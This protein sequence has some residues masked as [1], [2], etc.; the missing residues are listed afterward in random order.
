LG[1]GKHQSRFASHNVTQKIFDH[2]TSSE[3]LCNTL[4]LAKVMFRKEMLT[5]DI[6]RAM[7]LAFEAF[8]E[9]V[10]MDDA[11]WAFKEAE[12]EAID[13]AE[14][15][16]Q[17][18]RSLAIPSVGNV[19]T[20]CKTAMQKADHFQRALL[21]IVRLFYPEA[22]QMNWDDAQELVQKLYGEPDNFSKV[23]A[24]TVP[25]LKLVRN[26]RD[27]LEHHL[28]GVTTKDFELQ[29][30]GMIAPPTIEVDFRQSSQERCPVLWFMEETRKALLNAFE[31]IVVHLCS[32]HV[33]PFA[34]MPIV[35]APLPDNYKAAWHVRF[36]YGMYY[37]DGQFAPIG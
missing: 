6:N 9:L 3:V 31:M 37:A 24:L 30:D 28:K 27:C 33:Q 35:V 29:S 21:K 14:R 25:M 19:G 34:G 12:Q 26:V 20:Y 32:K 36:A 10:A 18:Q 11:V 2:G 7:Q 4:L 22:K 15:T 17:Q 8:G 16:P 5:I 23:M 1:W 13:K